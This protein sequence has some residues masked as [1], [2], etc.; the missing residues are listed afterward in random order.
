[1][2]IVHELNLGVPATLT[3]LGQLARDP[4]FLDAAV[5]VYVIDERGQFGCLLAASGV[6]SAPPHA[7][8]LQRLVERRAPD[9]SMPL[10]LWSNNAVLLRDITEMIRHGRRITGSSVEAPDAL[11]LHFVDLAAPGASWGLAGSHHNAAAGQRQ[12]RIVLVAPDDERASAPSFVAEMR[13][14][15]EQVGLPRRELLR[16]LGAAIIARMTA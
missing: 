11:D 2:L 12:P 5:L 8:S 4:A 16:A 7:L 6:L 1:V 13:A 3:T 15:V 10:Q 14:L 9:A